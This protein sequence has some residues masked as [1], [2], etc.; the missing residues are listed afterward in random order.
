M[1]EFL[2]GTFGDCA[3][4]VGTVAHIEGEAMIV[5]F[6]MIDCSYPV[7]LCRLEARLLIRNTRTYRGPPVTVKPT[8]SSIDPC[9]R[10]GL[11]L[12]RACTCIFDNA[13]VVC[14]SDKHQRPFI[15]AINCST[16]ESDQVIGLSGEQ[17]LLYKKRTPP[18]PYIAPIHEI[19][20][21]VDYG[22]D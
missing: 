8:G 20:T 9:G 21:A 13:R 7:Q 17:I 2:V 1:Q 22:S 6:V 10:E 11:P 4:C 16:P 14:L 18:G 12:E 19:A 5:T 3:G 15:S